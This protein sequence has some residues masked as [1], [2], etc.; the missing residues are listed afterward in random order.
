MTQQA[1]DQWRAAKLVGV[2][3]YDSDQKKVGSIRDILMDH[4]GNAQTIVIGI[5]GFLGIGTKDV[6]VPFKSV[7]W[8]TESR[9]LTVNSPNSVAN[10]TPPAT[11][12]TDPAATEAS[13][14]YPDKAMIA[15]TEEQLKA[16]PE[17][18]YAASPATA[19]GSVTAPAAAGAA[20]NA[21]QNAMTPKPNTPTKD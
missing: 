8:R 18:Q 4:D 6:A 14:G 21:T 10:G 12:K 19:G 2:G 1:L 20:V 13:Q 7:Q 9:E 16:A 15:M 17:F 5:G 11:V 3:V